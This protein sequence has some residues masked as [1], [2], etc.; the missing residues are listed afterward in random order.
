MNQIFLLLR[1]GRFIDLELRGCERNSNEIEEKTTTYERAVI[2]DQWEKKT[3]VEYKMYTVEE[4]AQDILNKFRAFDLEEG[5]EV[6]SEIWT[7][8]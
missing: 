8:Y 5:T 3:L 4:V 2:E 7:G 6:V 1:K